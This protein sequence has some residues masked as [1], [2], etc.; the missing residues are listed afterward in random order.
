[1]Y[2]RIGRQSDVYGLIRRY[3]DDVQ[4]IQSRFTISRWVRGLNPSALDAVLG[5]VFTAIAVVSIFNPS[6]GTVRYTD[7]NA[8][9][10]L[11]ALAF[12]L[13][14]FFRRRAPFITAMLSETALVLIACFQHP[15]GVMSQLFLV[16]SYTVGS[17][18]EGAKRWIGFVLIVAGP[19]IVAAVGIP[20]STT[21]NL[22]LTAGIYAG[23]FFLGASMR[24][25]R[26]YL[27][28]LEERAALLERERDEEA[29]RAVADERLRIA[30]E[31]HD[32]VAHSMGVIAVQAGVGA[33]V[34]DTD[35][36]EAKRSLEAISATSRTTLTEIRRLLGVLRS[37]DDASYVPAPG[38]G[39]LERLVQEM[40]DA[41]VDA[42]VTFHGRR[43]ELPP[44]VD[45]TAY[46]VIQESLT[47]V[48]K[49]G[50]PSVHVDVTL[51]FEPGLLG[52]EVADDGRGVNGR[53]K[54]GGHGLVGMRERVAVFGGSFDAGPAPGGGFRVAVI[55]PHGDAE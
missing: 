45:L 34:I 51:T 38:L 43:E 55:L 4:P 2:A 54:E 32:V 47:N 26:L 22:T 27:E 14:F 21:A 33:H 5:T 48:L 3:V 1:M 42:H 15:A 18:S 31:L 50:G 52:I 36:A 23:A 37:G 28:Q 12:G 46:R 17:W 20:D 11:L 39:D 19:L 35:P 16:A 29:K 49:H 53:A 9:T 10:V 30:Q 40:C 24:N 8:G 7:V 41:G 25:R 13:P 44:G 6:H